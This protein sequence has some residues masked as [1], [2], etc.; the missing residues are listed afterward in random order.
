MNTDAVETLPRVFPTVVHMLADAAAHFP[1][2]TAL[3]CGSR[4]LSYTQYLRCVAG[5]AEELVGCGARGGRVALVCANS[6]DVPI[7]M[8]ARMP[9][10]R[11][12]FL[13]IRLIPSASLATFSKTPIRLRLFTTPRSRA[14]SSRSRRRSASCAK[15]E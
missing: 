1:K 2:Q 8:S 6:L 5:F 3:I 4:S 11:K 12:R 13:S 15:C 14:K 7:A 9:R 10:A